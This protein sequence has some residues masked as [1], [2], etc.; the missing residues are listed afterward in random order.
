[1]AAA[2]RRERRSRILVRS[3]V[4]AFV[5]AVLGVVALVVASGITP[6]G[7]GPRNMAGDGI[8]VGTG[9]AAVRTPPLAAGETPKPAPTRTSAATAD[10]RLYT[11]F[12]CP[13]CGAFEKENGA[14]LED[15]VEKGAAT[16]ELHPV[17]ILDRLSLGTKYSTRSTAAAACV[18]D[19]SPDSFFAFSRALFSRQPPENSEG[20]TNGEIIGVAKGITGL[21]NAA[22]V[23]GCIDDQRFA[24]WVAEATRRALTGPLPGTDDEL[25]VTPTVIVNGKQFDASKQTFTEFVAAR[26]GAAHDG[27]AH[28]GA[29]AHDGAAHESG[30]E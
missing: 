28:D 5:L 13:A 18:A 25:K 26:L 17:A 24:G 9:L 29:V 12:L 7:P 15:L 22:K 21:E 27:A 16:V 20:L 19:Y 14:Y 23:A 10:I 3:G 2:D 11:D 6:A 1:V 4:A 30:S 8:E